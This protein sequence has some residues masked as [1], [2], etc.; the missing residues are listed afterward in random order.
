M[1]LVIF[2]YM[3]SWSTFFVSIYT[4]QLFNSS[5]LISNISYFLMI[6]YLLYLIFNLSLYYHFIYLINF[7]I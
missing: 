7:F 1:K 6:K 5:R 3:S 4:T 2:T